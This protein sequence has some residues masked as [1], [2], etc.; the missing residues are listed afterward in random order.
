MTTNKSV[1]K[2]RG[3]TSETTVSVNMTIKVMKWKWLE[4][5]DSKFSCSDSND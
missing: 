4:L 3:K 1:K 2:C 5:S